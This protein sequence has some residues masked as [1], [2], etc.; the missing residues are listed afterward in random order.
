MLAMSCQD[1][2]LIRRLGLVGETWHNS[3]DNGFT[4]SSRS[5]EATR[6]MGLS[7]K[8]KRK[9]A[10]DENKAKLQYLPYFEKSLGS[11]KA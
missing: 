6:L 9:E 10:F 1:V 8:D 11:F 7:A 5:T 3:A 4:V 2:C